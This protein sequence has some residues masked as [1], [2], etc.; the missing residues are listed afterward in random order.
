MSTSTAAETRA[1]ER[2]RSQWGILVSRGLFIFM[3][4]IFASGQD[5]TES[6][7]PDALREG[8]AFG[9]QAVTPNALRAPVEARRAV[10]KAVTAIANNQ[11]TEAEKQLSRALDL[12]PDYAKALTLRAI[13]KMT[14]HRARSIEDLDRAIQL[15]P[16]YGLAYAVLASIYND[17]Q[18][19]D[20]ALSVVVRAMQLLPAAWPV[21]YEMAR[22]L[23]GKHRNV[24]ALREVSN[25]I[26]RISAG[27]RSE[28]QSRA[29]LHYLRGRI[30]MDEHEF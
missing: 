19:Y 5:V 16:G 26:E 7:R 14:T 18:R 24:E 27:A 9:T 17:S 30:L 13:S 10:Q 25:A 1:D 15:D 4:P 21:H 12:Y 20:D 29:T 2:R 28:P 11:E 23:F 8:G 3:F 6:S 22:T